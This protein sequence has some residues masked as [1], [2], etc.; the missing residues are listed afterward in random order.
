MRGIHLTLMVL[1]GMT[2]GAVVLTGDKSPAG[3]S[4]GVSG[5]VHGESARVVAQEAAA[6]DSLLGRI[7]EF[8][9]FSGS[10]LVARGDSVLVH[11]GYGLASERPCVRAGPET[12]Y[13]IGSLAKQFAATAALRLEE[14]GLWKLDDS[15]VRFLPEA[16]ADK[17]AIT[18]HQLLAHTSGLPSD[19]WAYD[20]GYVTRD[21]AVGRLLEVPLDSP[22]GTRYRYSNAGYTL[23][24]ALIEYATG[25]P[26]EEYARR[27]LFV[28]AG[29]RRTGFVEGV[30]LF[31]DGEVAAGF[32][33]RYQVSPPTGRPVSWAL[34]PGDILSTVGDLARW[35]DALRSGH[36]LSSASVERMFTPQFADYGYGWHVRTREDG[37]T[38]VIFHNGDQGEHA[39]AFRHYPDSD[40]VAVAA[41][42][43]VLQ[44]AKQHDDVLNNALEV[45]AGATIDLPPVPS[46]QRPLPPPEGAYD[47]DDAVSFRLS[48]DS[49]AGLW[50]APQSRGAFRVM[51]GH[52]SDFDARYDA[53][54]ARTSVFE[55][56]LLAAAVCDS[57]SSPKWSTD[58]PQ[59]VTGFDRMV[60]DLTRE[61]GEHRKTVLIGARP[62][63][64]SRSRTFAFADHVHDRGRQVV[65]W[66]WEENRP[67][68]AWTSPAIDRPQEIALA[69]ELTGFLAYDW[70]TGESVRVRRSSAVGEQVELV[71]ERGDESVRVRRV[72]RAP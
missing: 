8:G 71:I 14:Q 25:E 70:F 16:P 1:S 29:L 54:L 51:F 11:A 55:D 4:G 63:S 44:D 28:R 7:A 17:R 21:S 38:S 6:V 3:A 32:W 23:L 57:T 13:H 46:V 24:T 45:I 69:E 10:V 41:T 52:L 40:L 42:N 43:R 67:V 18:I 2:V 30:D 22:P 35:Y 26:F 12:A 49:A 56:S 72:T 61:L 50:L 19:V 66:L 48:A 9:T 27:E 20:V 68:E 59:Y 64:W 31:E 47:G 33:G 39:V 65:T 53:S 58:S 34:M 36:I 37:S 15:L 62:L 60:C 5:C